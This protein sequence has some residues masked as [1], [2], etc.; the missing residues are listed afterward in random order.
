MKPP[1]DRRGGSGEL[2]DSEVRQYNSKGIHK[3]FAAKPSSSA[4]F[5]PLNLLTFLP[6]PLPPLLPLFLTC[7]AEGFALSDLL[8]FFTATHSQNSLNIKK[9]TKLQ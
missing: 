1:D 5:L 2:K 4:L 6:P 8:S 3:Q 7:A 9:A